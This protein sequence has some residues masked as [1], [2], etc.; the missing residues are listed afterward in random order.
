MN[1]EYTL[2]AH[3]K[4]EN[5]GDSNVGYD[6]YDKETN[7]YKWNI[8]VPNGAE[9]TIQENY[10]SENPNI[11]SFAKYEVKNS[12][13]GSYDKEL[14]DYSNG[15]FKVTA[16]SIASDKMEELQ[17]EITVVNLKNEYLFKDSLTL[18]KKDDYSK[19]SMNGVSFV[20]AGAKGVWK[21]TDNKYYLSE[22]TKYGVKNALEVKDKKLEVDEGGNL[23]IFYNEDCIGTYTLTEQSKTGYGAETVNF[24]ISKGS[25]GRIE[26]KKT[27]TERVKFENSDGVANA[28]TV[29]NKSTTMKLTV[30]KDWGETEEEDKRSVDIE[31]YRKAKDSNV[32]PT[33]VYVDEESKAINDAGVN[34]ANSSVITLDKDNNWEKEIEVPKYVNG[35]LQEYSVKEIKIGDTE[36]KAEKDAT[37]GYLFY[38]VQ[39]PKPVVADVDSAELKVVNSIEGAGFEFTKVDKDFATKKLSSA[40]FAL[41]EGFE[42]GDVTGDAVKTATSVAD[43]KIIFE[44]LTQETYYMKETAAPDGYKLS[45]MVYE[46]KISDNKVA[47]ITIKSENSNG[48]T[49]DRLEGNDK[50]ITNEIPRLTDISLEKLSDQS[51]EAL[52]GAQFVLR[53]TDGTGTKYIA[54]NAEEVFGKPV[55]WKIESP[56]QEAR[57]IT[58]EN[59]IVPLP[60]LEAGEYELIEVEA[61]AGYNLL[62]ESVKFRVNDSLQLEVNTATES[63]MGIAKKADDSN[64]IIVMNSTGIALPETGGPGTAAYTFGGLAMIIAVSLMYGLNMRRKRE[65]GGMM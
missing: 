33:L 31:L 7:T 60:N 41:Y 14:T 63:S 42:N 39:L 2:K 25:D 53:K 11:T 38:K 65:K 20:L 43:G 46:V 49:N 55:D 19:E 50:I 62:T 9:C 37:D 61:P 54:G 56:S 18:H 28:V 24:E 36:F 52:E 48:N 10:E 47:S 26:L 44:N 30:K 29:Y 34:N 15:G 6:F 12:K 1:Y 32:K 5:D 27:E 8:Y 23:T 51:K 4:T 13:G 35:V 40:T 57:F 16:Q 21:D 64:T 17:D 58:G 22:P 45:N 59:G 3:P